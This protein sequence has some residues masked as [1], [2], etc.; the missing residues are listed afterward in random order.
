[1]KDSTKPY[2]ALSLTCLIWGTTYL[3]NK[4]GVGLIPPFLFT[5]VRH[6]ISGIIMLSLVFI[7]Q[8]EKWPSRKY[9][10]FQAL[11]GFFLLTIGNGIGVIGLK[12]IDSGLSAILAATSPILISL[13]VHRYTPQDKIGPIAWIGMF[14][15]FIGLLI[16]C[17]DKIKFPLH[18][19]SNFIGISLTLISVLSWGGASVLSK[20]KNYQSSPFMAAGFQMIFGSLPLGFVSIF[21]EDHSQFHITN[22]IIGVWIYIIILGS[23]VAYSSYIYALKHLPAPIVSVQSYIN[24]IIAMQLGYFVLGEVFSS[25]LIIGSILTLIGVFVLNYSE[26]KRKKKINTQVLEKSL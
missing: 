1:M 19:D 18:L 5:S 15:G 16:I 10:M 22:D 6:A 4:V 25:K 2:I 8:K 9:L 12:Y 3:V 20:T 14:I 23:L 26:F 7:F 11:L 13:L 24:P 17:V 21:I